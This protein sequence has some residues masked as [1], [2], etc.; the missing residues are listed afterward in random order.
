MVQST[1]NTT[2]NIKANKQGLFLG[3]Q[4]E[5]FNT[6]PSNSIDAIITDP[7]YGLKWKHQ[8]ETHFNFATFLENCYRVLKPNG[9]L[10]YFG[11]E[12]SIS[13]WNHLAGQQFHYLAEIIWYK[14][15]NS[16]PFHFPLRV[17]EKIMIFTKGNGK[18]QKATLD[19]EWEKEEILEYVQKSTI[20]RAISEI[21]KL[22]K[23]STTIDDL[24]AV[25]DDNK[26]IVGTQKSKVNDSIYKI[27]KYK[28]NKHSYI[29]NP[30]KLT[31]LWGCR[32]HNHQG[33][34]KDEF[35]IKHPTVKPMQIMERLLAMTTQ[36]GD[37]VLDCF[38][39][40]G[41]TGVTCLKNNRKF[42][43]FELIPEYYNIAKQRITEAK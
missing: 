8:I 38:M 17:H 1:N 23:S 27:N 39:G 14:R 21:K 13:S 15:G 5:L 30:K 3:D 24:K 34:G 43:G 12:P 4:E 31:T 41:T 32:P 33:Y 18:L 9:F 28:L 10:V 36:E 35:N 25:I 6:I 20:L 2:L 37:L 29:F 11:Q 40:S 26:Y 16:S 7:P 22:L 19:W 42:I